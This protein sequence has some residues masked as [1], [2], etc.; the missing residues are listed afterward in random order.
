MGS[1]FKEFGD[2]SHKPMPLP[3]TF[4]SVFSKGENAEEKSEQGG[5]IQSR[6]NQWFVFK[7]PAKVEYI[8]NHDD[9]CQ[10]QGFDYGHPVIFVNNIVGR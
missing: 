7:T 2:A 10:Y 8:S 6:I 4:N 5:L 3:K 9:L 1:F